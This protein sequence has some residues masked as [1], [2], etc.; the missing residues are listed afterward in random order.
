V[1]NLKL[2]NESTNKSS[3]AA[4]EEDGVCGLWTCARLIQWQKFAFL[5]CIWLIFFIT[6]LTILGTNEFLRAKEN[7]EAAFKPEKK[8]KTINHWRPNDE[9]P[10]Y[11]T[12]Y[13][14]L[15]FSI[16]DFRLKNTNET[17]Q[18]NE[19]PLNDTLENLLKSQNNFLDSSFIT[20]ISD[21]QRRRRES[22]PIEEAKAY[23]WSSSVSSNGSWNG[24][25]GYFRLMVASPKNRVG[26][27]EYEV[28]INMQA[29]TLNQ[30]VSVGGLWLSIGREV[31]NTN[32][33]EMVY[34]NTE[35][36]VIANSSVSMYAIV[37]YTEKITRKISSE[38]A[39][40]FSS[41]LEWIETDK[42]SKAGSGCLKLVLRPDL[43]IDYWAEYIDY[44]YYDWFSG[45]GGIIQI[46]SMIFFWGAY[47]LAIFFGERNKMGIL[48]EM[49]FIFHN[50]ETIH[51]LKYKAQILY[52]KE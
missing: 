25:R 24:F 52:N 22:L 32:W 28:N 6:A 43:M 3:Y 35:D 39:H 33:G 19:V 51:L 12:P 4:G 7:T 38:H 40:S 50:F 17:Y 26:Y 49:S 45:M 15:Y 16:G 37:D 42:R 11:E 34:V 41:S 8:L 30:T 10:L 31:A 27:F 36:L 29:L 2:H 5:Q 1:K 46:A 21:G 47:Y 44:D 20:Y 23:C 14:Y 9:H 48:P 18:S 13:I